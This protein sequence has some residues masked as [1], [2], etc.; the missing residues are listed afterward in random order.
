[1]VGA[2]TINTP[3]PEALLFKLLLLSGEGFYYIS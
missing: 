1:M 2:G 3:L